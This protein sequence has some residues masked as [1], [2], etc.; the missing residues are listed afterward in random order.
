MTEPIVETVKLRCPDCGAHVTLSVESLLDV[1]C[2]Q[3]VDSENTGAPPNWTPW[4]GGENPIVPSHAL[5][6]VRFNDG[7]ENYKF[8]AWSIDRQNRVAA[9]RKAVDDPPIITLFGKR[10]TRLDKYFSKWFVRPI[11]Q[12]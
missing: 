1:R 5:V 10:R 3:W 2:L 6:D 8:K 9:Y 11:C 12:R 4:L 7:V